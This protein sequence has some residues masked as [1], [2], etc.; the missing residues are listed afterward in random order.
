MKTNILVVC[1]LT[2]FL[3]S[4]FIYAQN[5]EDDSEDLFVYRLPDN[6][7]PVS[8]DLR[9]KPIVDLKNDNYTFIGQVDI[10]IRVI[11]YT[12][13]VTLNSKN[14]NISSVSRFRDLKTKRYTAVKEYYHEEKTDQMVIR[15]S[16]SIVP[17]RLYNFTINFEGTLNNNFMGL[18][19]YFYDSNDKSRYINTILLF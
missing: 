9:M 11:R 6:T 4:S 10:V 18:H 19:R 3:S 2:Y 17:P 16:K 5:L 12:T 1:L 13:E 15:L 8:Y 7:E 14:L